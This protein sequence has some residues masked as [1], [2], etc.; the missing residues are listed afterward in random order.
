MEIRLTLQQGGDGTTFGIGV[1][2]DI[3]SQIMS[4][5]NI[6]LTN[7]GDLKRFVGWA[8]TFIVTDAGGR[9]EHLRAINLEFRLVDQNHVPWSNWEEELAVVRE[10]VPGISRLSGEMLRRY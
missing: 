1:V 6:D 8:G 9:G 5:L 2:N 3:D 10:A 4:I 7:L